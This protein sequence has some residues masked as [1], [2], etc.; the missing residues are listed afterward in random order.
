MKFCIH[1]E[2]LKRERMKVKH[3]EKRIQLVIEENKI[4]K[5]LLLDTGK[6]DKIPTP[7]S[8]LY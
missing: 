2:E 4:L 7:S 6:H 5:S 1:E 8:N 3:L